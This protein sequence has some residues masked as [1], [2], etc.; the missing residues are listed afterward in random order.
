MFQ[1]WSDFVVD[2][3]Q[4]LLAFVVH[5]FHFIIIAISGP[6]KSQSMPCTPSIVPCQIWQNIF[7]QV[8][9][10]R[11]LAASSHIHTSCTQSHL[12]CALQ[13]DPEFNKNQHKTQASQHYSFFRFLDK[14]GSN[15][16]VSWLRL[17][18]PHSHSL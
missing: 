7:L 6:N 15:G 3:F 14:L 2:L 8:S 11:V 16:F 10:S 12:P 5:E 1:F 9:I 4:A 13:N 18:Y 17:F